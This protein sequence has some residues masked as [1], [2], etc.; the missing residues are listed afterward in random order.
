ME[1][2]SSKALPGRAAAPGGG[3]GELLG[4]KMGRTSP[5]LMPVGKQGALG[6]VKVHHRRGRGGHGLPGLPESKD[7]VAPAAP[8]GAVSLGEQGGAWLLKQG[9]DGRR[10][11]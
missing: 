7:R 8:G 10:P 1:D 2:T 4:I 11:G 6:E 3:A 5:R 9:Q